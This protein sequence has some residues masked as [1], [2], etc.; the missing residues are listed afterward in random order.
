MSTTEQINDKPNAPRKEI[1]LKNG[2]N[3]KYILNQL[4]GGDLIT[5]LTLLVY[6]VFL[7]F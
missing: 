6:F 1:L 4:G 3:K 5:N 7:F 2:R